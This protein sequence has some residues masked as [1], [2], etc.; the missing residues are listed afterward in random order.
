MG[1]PQDRQDNEPFLIFSFSEGARLGSIP[2][3]AFFFM[4]RLFLFLVL[5]LFPSVSFSAYPGDCNI[6]L[7]RCTGF[8]ALTGFMGWQ[9]GSNGAVQV[10]YPLESRN[11]T[12]QNCQVYN[13]YTENG[14]WY[15]FNGGGNMWS[16]GPGTAVP[17]GIALNNPSALIAAGYLNSTCT[18]PPEPCDTNDDDGDGVCNTC[19]QL[20][21]VPDKDD[22][23]MGT[24]TNTAG[25]TTSAVIDK[26]C[27]GESTE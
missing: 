7:Y 22:C 20:P 24:T 18:P 25:E 27:N 4:I 8:T 21:G 12:S 14:G 26:N 6:V 13:Y 5:I 10:I 3:R 2:G 19:D 17:E 23:L 11:Y 1:F 15:S 16:T 9:I